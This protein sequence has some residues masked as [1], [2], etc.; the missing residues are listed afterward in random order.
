VPLLI[1]GATG[2][3]LGTKASAKFVPNQ[4]LRQLF[5]ILIVVMTAY[6]IL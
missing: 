2:A 5:G 6:K 4:R 1:A 3:F